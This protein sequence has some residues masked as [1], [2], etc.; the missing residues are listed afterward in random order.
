MPI[1]RDARRCCR[2]RS[3]ARLADATFRKDPNFGFDVPVT[4]PGV[5]AG[6][7]DPRST[8]ADKHAYD[9]QARKLVAMFSENFTQYESHIDDDVPRGGHRLG[10]A[11]QGAARAGRPGMTGGH[12]PRPPLA[13]RP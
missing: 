3:T 10:A 9:A 5:D 7:L 11:R 4:V 6:L 2:R 8:W 1:A 12:T 13:A